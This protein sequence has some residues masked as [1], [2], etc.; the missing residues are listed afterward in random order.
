MRWRLGCVITFQFLSSC[1]LSHLSTKFTPP[2]LRGG[3]WPPMF[4]RDPFAVRQIYNW[5][6]A[7]WLPIFCQIG[8]RIQEKDGRKFEVERLFSLQRGLDRVLSGLVALRAC[9]GCWILSRAVW[10]RLFPFHFQQVQ[11]T[12]FSF[13]FLNKFGTK[14]FCEI[15]DFEQVQL[16][17]FSF[18]FLNKFGTKYFCEI[19]DFEPVG[20]TVQWP[21]TESGGMLAQLLRAATSRLNSRVLPEHSVLVLATLGDKTYP[22]QLKIRL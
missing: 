14:Y 7:T 16:T 2:L 3:E 11:L 15:L 10:C 18:I 5:I 12:Y 1:R 8:S 20:F 9:V 21:K 17:Y 4:V 22:F 6:A 19:F 13:I